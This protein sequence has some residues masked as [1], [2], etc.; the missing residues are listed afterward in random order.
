MRAL[1][2][3]VAS[4]AMAGCRRD[5]SIR[6]DPAP[7]DA[8][9]A[10]AREEEAKAPFDRALIHAT[11]VDVGERRRV[12][13]VAKDL[14]VAEADDGRRGFF[15][16][17]GG[18]LHAVDLADGKER[19]VAHPTGCRDL[20]VARTRVAC[21]A[22]AQIEAFDIEKGGAIRV[23]APIV[24]T[25]SGP[26]DVDVAVA[27]ADVLVVARRDRSA[28]AYDLVTG[29]LRGSSTLPGN[30]WRGEMVETGEGARAVISAGTSFSVVALDDRAALRTLSTI[31]LHRAGDPP[32]GSFGLR[33]LGVRWAVVGTMWSFYSG[34][35]RSAV[36]RLSDGAEMLRVEDEIGAAIEEPGG[37]LAGAVALTS[38]SG[39]TPSTLQLFDAKGKSV[40]NVAAPM[41]FGD[42]ASAVLDGER[43]VIATF[44]RIASGAG[45]AAFD[46]K[47][48][49]SLWTGDVELLPIAHSKY[50]NAVVVSLR[51]G[52]IAMRGNE[53]AFSYFELFDRATGK[54]TFSELRKRW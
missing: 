42:S 46:R 27:L 20:V 51:S 49:A 7:E 31:D 17:T 13:E 19:W 25:L 43:I 3:F 28:E 35:R 33:S 15:F 53:A 34:V 50:S 10:D 6:K 30:L 8:H 16:D 54:R 5:A 48:G 52:A 47:T 18:L 45:L 40:W 39:K 9:V 38:G 22:G 24:T 4:L 12:L 14:P 26:R 37:A 11:I 1:L 32:G 29:A 41:L 36:L 23:L 2:L 44:H 21:I